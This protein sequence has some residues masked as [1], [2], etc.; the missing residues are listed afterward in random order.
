MPIFIYYLRDSIQSRSSSFISLLLLLS[1][2][3]QNDLLLFR[4]LPLGTGQNVTDGEN[5]AQGESE[6]ERPAGDQCSSMGRG[7]TRP[8]RHITS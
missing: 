2:N 8:G 6:E 7:A 3:N 5:R 1:K 4:L